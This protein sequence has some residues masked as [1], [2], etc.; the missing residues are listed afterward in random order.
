MATGTT[1]E[2]D[3]RSAREAQEYFTPDAASATPRG[4]GARATVRTWGTWW[5]R[6]REASGIRA[7]RT[8]AGRWAT[9]VLGSSL[10]DLPVE[11]VSAKDARAFVRDLEV[12]KTRGEGPPR[13]LATQTKK[14]VLNLVRCAFQTAVEEEIIGANPFV[15]LKVRKTPTTRQGFTVLDVS[16]QVSALR[17]VSSSMRNVVAFALGTGMRAGELWG[18]EWVDVHVD[19]K[20]PHVVVR[21]SGHRRPTKSGKPRVVPLFGLALD[22]IRL[23]KKNF[24]LTSAA[25]RLTGNPLGLV[26]P[27]RSGK[28]RQKGAP[29]GWHGWMRR[30]GIT[31]RVRFHDLRHTCGASLVSGWWGRAWSLEEVRQLFGH[32]T[33]RMAERYAHFAQDLLGRA[34]RE[35][36]E[37]TATATNQE[38]GLSPMKHERRGSDS[39]RRMTVLQTPATEH[40][41]SVPAR[42][43]WE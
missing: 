42:R 16:E 33:I 9:H 38:S 24:E 15:G 6:M 31:R 34:A 3:E 35:A 18:L 40:A 14:N 10:A 8:D 27:R 12:R 19:G 25:I 1:T 43:W 23:H 36:D 29:K 13:A 20:A 30:A 28:P 2:L 26:F 7:A 11:L 21:Y 4:G 22:A 39:N 32:S 17:A 5:L 37:Q 41:T